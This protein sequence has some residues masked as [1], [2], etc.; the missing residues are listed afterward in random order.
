MYF[1]AGLFKKVVIADTVAPAANAVFEATAGGA[2]VGLMT[3]WLGVVS[4]SIQ[5]YFDFSGYSDMAI[6]L[7]LAVGVTLPLNFNSPYK[8]RDIVDFWRRWH[9]TLSTFLRDYLYVPLGGNRKGKTRR[10]ANLAITMLLGGLWHGAGWTF[11]FW[12]ALHGTYLVINHVVRAVLGTPSS[13]GLLRRTAGRSITLLAV[14][15]AWVFFRADSFA[16]AVRLLDSMRGGHGLGLTPAVL[17]VLRR[18]SPAGSSWA[19]EQI[20]DNPH[21]VELSVP[22]LAMMSVAAVIALWLPNTQQLIALRD[23]PTTRRWFQWRPGLPWGVLAGVTAA[24]ALM[25]MRGESEFLYFQF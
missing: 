25:A 3:S 22:S 5:L 20:L 10:Y 2:D 18:V 1:A 23:N 24:W 9:I 15:V 8:A 14:M 21:V 13:P 19:S 7:G 17:P 4:Y 16:T 6:G 11:V 12:G